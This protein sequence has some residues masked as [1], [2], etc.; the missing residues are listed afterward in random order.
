M[1]AIKDII[2][3]ERHRRHM[4]DIAAL[5]AS[6]EAVG[7]LHPPVVD[8]NNMLVAGERRIRAALLLGWTDIQVNEIDIAEIVLGEYAESIRKDFTLSEAV[9][10]KRAVAPLIEADAKAR[11]VLGG[12]LKGEAGA[13][14]AQDAGKAR[15]KIAKA[16]GT[17]HTT[18]AKAEKVVEAAEAEP[19][20]FGHLVEEM[21]RIGK[22]DGAYKQLKA[23][24]P[25][26]ADA[27]MPASAEAISDDARL[28]RGDDQ[29]EPHIDP[30]TLSIS[31]QQKLAAAIRQAAS[32]L[33]V[34]YVLRLRDGVRDGVR[35][36]LESILP[37]YAVMEKSY[38]DM[39]E[40]R[41]KG[42][43]DKKT[44]R[45]IWSCLHTDSR[46]SVTDQKL[47]EAFHAFSKL[48]TRL[49]SERDHPTPRFKMPT[50]DE[51]MARN[52]KANVKRKAKRGDRGIAKAGQ[53]EADKSEQAARKAKRGGRRVAKV[54]AGQ[55]ATITQTEIETLAAQIADFD[56]D[57]EWPVTQYIGDL[58]G[59]LD[60]V[61]IRAVMIRVAEI[62]PSSVFGR[63]LTKELKWLGGTDGWRF[64]K[65]GQPEAAA[66]APAIVP[67]V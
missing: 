51:L 30:A 44:F 14:L 26:P 32:K 1:V 5:A 53:P 60:R 2:I 3:G 42:I 18:L 43:M 45:L 37:D 56:E 39:M 27:A 50:Y 28:T 59:N 16:T 17:K 65:A 49:M 12:K 52:A 57:G 29:A 61:D 33:Q 54:E 24:K 21:D 40:S 9:A 62:N 11:Q 15:D 38:Q 6:I 19:E 34:D 63:F 41:V 13:N 67:E 31:A 4:G 22:V 64:C 35:N 36:A 47:N 23:S 25:P 7:L 20:K 8:K 55:P 58:I 46:A 10:I 48:E 66:P